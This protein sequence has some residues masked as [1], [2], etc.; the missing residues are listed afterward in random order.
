[1][2]Q[3]ISL[4]VKNKSL[5]D[6]FDRIQQQV[7]IDMLGDLNL[8]RNANKFD[9]R[10][11]NMELSNV[12]LRLSDKSEIDMFVDGKIVIIR[13]LTAERK[14]EISDRVKAS[15]KKSKLSGQIFNH[16]GEPLSGVSIRNISENRNVAASDQYGRFEIEYVDDPE[17]SFS[18]L[19]Y[20]S[21]HLKINGQKSLRIELQQLS[22]ALDSLDIN[23]G[24]S[25][26]KMS[27]FTG[28]ASI[29]SQNEL[30]NFNS[31][32]TLKIIE[33]I[34]PAFKIQDDIFNG[35]NP[36]QIPQITVRGINNVGNYVVNSPLII[37]D[38]FE[39]TLERLY[40]LDINR[41]ERI[42]LLKD[43]SSMVLYG[44]RGGNGVLLVETKKPKPGDIKISLD[45][46]LSLT[47]AD[48]SDYNLM[49]ASEKLEFES[50]AGK[51]RHKAALGESLN[52]QNINQTKLDNLYSQRLANVLEGVDTYW[53]KQPLQQE[54][55]NSASLRLEGGNQKFVYGISGNMSRLNAVMKGS[56]RDRSGAQLNLVYRPFTGLEIWS[57]SNY[58]YRTGYESP[59]GNFQDYALMN[60]YQRL[61]DNRGSLIAS[62]PDETLS[63]LK[64]NPLSNALLPY[65]DEIKR[66]LYSQSVFISYKINENF[67]LKSNINY[68]RLWDGAEKFI[69]PLNTQYVDKDNSNK[70][71]YRYST[72]NGNYITANVNLGYNRRI[73]AH[74]FQVNLV[75]EARSADAL[76]RGRNMIG[77]SH[78]QEL[79]SDMQSITAMSSTPFSMANKNRLVSGIVT[80]AYSFQNAYFMDFSYRMDGSSKFGQNNP[81][82]QFWSLGTAYNL[83]SKLLS[84]MEWITD[85]LLFV[86]TGVAG[87]DAFLNNMT[88]SS[89]L[90]AEQRQYLLEI[91]YLYNNQGNP[92]L[93][94]PK[95]S[96]TSLGTRTSLLQDRLRLSFFLYSKNTNRM[97]SLI[98]TA[99]SIGIPG[100]GYYENIGK[101]KNAGF[102]SEMYLRF[103]ESQD[104]TI[105]TE[106][107]LTAVRNRGKLLQLSEELK[108]MNVTNMTLDRFGNYNQTELY[109][110]GES[111]LNLKGVQSLGIDPATGKEYFLSKTNRITDQWRTDDIVVIG[112]KEAIVFGTMHLSMNYKAL[113]L[114]AYLYYSLGGQVY[115]YTSA[116]R[117]ENQD[118]WLNTDLRALQSRWIAPGDVTKFKNIGDADPSYLSSRFVEKESY[119]RLSSILFNYDVPLRLIERY[120]LKG[121]RLQMAAN[122]LLLSSTVNMER[123]LNYPM[124]RSFNFGLL[125]QF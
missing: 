91:G 32:N 21:S 57:S 122:D 58:E 25:Q 124:S 98:T 82:G 22:F 28:A 68:E 26:R 117:V 102:E 48:L 45:Y 50:F 60:P 118:P 120:R 107:S 101:V 17:L 10:V 33:A 78:D 112:N 90:N 7:K 19:G 69:S 83:K 54:I 108:N 81:Y 35:G 80:G 86:N 109:Q 1:M 14:R 64:Y 63:A 121:L 43:V 66:Q 51:Y 67:S 100:N 13:K 37:L 93:K 106:F 96:S 104:K 72:S 71:L 75:S 49:N 84:N 105:S 119:I 113:S 70:G 38:G 52:Q 24:Y 61:L 6:I 85:M 11:H 74:S 97:V 41:I 65:K 103:Y 76:E 23:T 110:V 4:D 123:G 87:T 30:R 36:N 116:T 94:W 111:L 12:L 88:T 44:S 39:V 18:M 77:L 53:L 115:N 73:A 62:Y 3:R 79:P 27:S 89:Y 92:N 99:P 16:L 56:R 9:F 42:V 15:V 95:I 125:T 114:Q 20:Q 2:A 31:N 55:S 40:D 8:L 47:G 5:V 46:R 59:F 34:E 29:I